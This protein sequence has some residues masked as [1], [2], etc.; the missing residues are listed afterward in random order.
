MRI[1]IA[2]GTGTVGRLVT[3]E[4]ERRGHD[5]VVLA[6]SV[7]VDLVTGEGLD[8]AL[9][10]A[11]AVIDTT[12]IGTLRAKDATA[13]FR[14]ASGALLAAA[15]QAGVGHALLL[16][17]VGIDRIPHGYYAG[18]LAQEEEYARSGVPVSLVRAT[19][20]HE[21]AGQVAAQARFGPVQL[22]PR[23][24][25]QPIAADDVATHLVSLAEGEPQGRSR[26]IAG[27]REERLSE[28][29]REWERHAGR[30]GPVWAIDLPSAQMRGMRRGLA[31]PGP[32][33]LVLGPRF[34]DWLRRQ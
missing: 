19:Q 18:K 4:A 28:M 23:A 5:A 30:R 14:A 21:F 27:P 9:D 29:V 24:R 8:G 7:G 3:R 34:S 2:G 22:A 6:R 20:F 12:S 10:G 33:A 32:D 16:S 31:L 26:D 17:I 15:A 25:V 13:F 1:A 11:D